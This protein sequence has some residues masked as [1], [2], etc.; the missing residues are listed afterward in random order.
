MWQPLELSRGQGRARG[1][2]RRLQVEQGVLGEHEVEGVIGKEFNP[3]RCGFLGG[4]DVWT[5]DV[6][7]L[8]VR[9]DR[10]IALARLVF[11]FSAPADMSGPH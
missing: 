1:T 9:P 10:L 2:G 6:L 11:C 3:V 5:L 8:G 4:R 7:N